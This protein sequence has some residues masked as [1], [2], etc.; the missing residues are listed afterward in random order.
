MYLLSS[1]TQKA[2]GEGEW[3]GKNQKFALGVAPDGPWLGL[4]IR[5]VM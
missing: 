3:F 4:V 5:A 1:G 2:P